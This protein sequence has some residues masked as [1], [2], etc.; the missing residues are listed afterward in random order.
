MIAS[1]MN[2][3]ILYTSLNIYRL[4]DSK[5]STFPNPDQMQEIKKTH[6]N[7]ARE[8]T[9]IMNKISGKRRSQRLN[10]LTQTHSWRS[11]IQHTHTHFAI[12]CTLSFFFLLFNFFFFSFQSNIH[13]YVL[14][15]S[16][17]VCWFR[18]HEPM[19]KPCEERMPIQWEQC[20]HTCAKSM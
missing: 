16:E 3:H 5:A 1:E 13:T 20:Y 12:F 6:K 11:S 15:K 10:I 19:M 2:T 14:C 9:K 4:M 8:P 7:K 18:L 17:K